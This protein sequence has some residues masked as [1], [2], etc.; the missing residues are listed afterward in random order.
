MAEPER[1]N[2]GPLPFPL[3]SDPSS[4]FHS[5]VKTTRPPWTERA[6][7][8]RALADLCLGCYPRFCLGLG[9]PRNLLPV[10]HF[11]EVSPEYLGPFLDHLTKGGYR[12]LDTEGFL[13]IVRA[14]K[15]IPERAVFLT[16]D[17]A[18]ASVWTVAEPLLRQRSQTAVTFAVPGRVS[19][20]PGLRTQFTE[21]T[22]GFD[23]G[24]R[25]DEPFARW[26][27]LRALERNRVVEVE[28]HTFAHEQVPAAP[29][30]ENWTAEALA[31]TPLLSLPVVREGSS[32]RPYRTG[33][34]GRPRHPTRPRMSEVRAWLPEEGRFETDEE[35]RTA[36]RE[37]LES[38]RDRLKEELG[39]SPRLLC[40][41]WAVAGPTA[42]REAEGAGYAAAFADHFPGK[43]YVRPGDN[44]YRLMRLKHQWLKK[45]P[46]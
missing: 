2:S 17:D 37:D 24:D 39:K 36:I 16:F 43:R 45:L 33:E 11:H 7:L 10:F 42:K 27:E 8:S 22:V 38:C 23:P 4:P 35:A 46:V 3:A 9:L 12:T 6:R 5:G 25:S 18:W 32:V 40:F 29:S 26:D 19:T 28:A 1:T 20:T 21:A 34:S 31:E 44:P 41:P 14:R 15:P 13:E 30:N